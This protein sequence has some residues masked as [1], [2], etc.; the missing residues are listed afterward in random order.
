MPIE[1]YGSG[2]GTSGDEPERST[3]PPHPETRDDW[4]TR[5]ERRVRRHWTSPITRHEAFWIYNT[6]IGGSL[7]A[8]LVVGV[9]SDYWPSQLVWPGL[10]LILRAVGELSGSTRRPR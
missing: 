10:Y 2:E 7:F 5:A 8:I 4:L 9:E 6:M 1:A 3:L